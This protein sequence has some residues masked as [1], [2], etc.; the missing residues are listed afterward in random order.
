[1][2]ASRESSRLYRLESSLGDAGAPRP[3]GALGAAARAL[4]MLVVRVLVSALIHSEGFW[5][6]GVASA[7]A[8]PAKLRAEMVTRYRWPS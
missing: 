3:R 4:V 7:Y 2:A 8:D 6:K 1:M 5:S